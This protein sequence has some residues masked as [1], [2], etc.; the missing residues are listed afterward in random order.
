[1]TE[2]AFPFAEPNI[3][4]AGTYFRTASFVNP[5][6]EDII[7]WREAIEHPLS[8]KWQVQ[9]CW[10]RPNVFNN[11]S[12]TVVETKPVENMQAMTLGAAIR[13][14]ATFEYATTKME[15][16]L[17]ESP[18]VLGDEHV[19]IFAGLNGF[20]LDINNNVH[21]LHN[22]RPVSQG[23]F[24]PQAL[25]TAQE[26]LGRKPKNKPFVADTNLSHLFRTA[27]EV[28]SFDHIL[29]LKQQSEQWKKNS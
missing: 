26:N 24:T 10:I 1:M 6:A 23:I 20:V 3:S 15:M 28:D 9:E 11:D 5:M 27:V 4:S 22:G 21:V 14:L 17:H 13:E 7:V 16:P 2:Q 25:K 18:D 8:N 19:K 29:D 12:D